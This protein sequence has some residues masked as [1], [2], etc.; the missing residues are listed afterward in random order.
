MALSVTDG[1]LVIATLAGPVLAVQAQKWLERS[2]EK[3]QRKKSIF[4]ALMG[5]RATRLAEEHVR[6]LN[7][8]DLEFTLG[9][10]KER[11][12]IDAWRSYSLQLNIPYDVTSEAQSV[13]WNNEV[14][15][16]FI[17]LLF[18]MSKAVGFDFT[19]EHLQRGIYYP[20]GHAELE[21]DRSRVLKNA[22]AVLSGSQPLQMEIIKFPVSSE[23][24]EAQLK[25]QGKLSAAI[26]ETGLKVEISGNPTRGTKLR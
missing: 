10:P 26:G 15:R 13:S 24:V 25:L 5:T 11:A 17:E 6:A 14:Y 3:D 2:R 1:L 20:T 4:Y 12:V 16:L 18:V 21:A 19:K 23:M 9:R 22:A 7:S 8:I